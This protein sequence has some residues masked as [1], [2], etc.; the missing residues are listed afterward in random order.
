MSYY[1]LC[2]EQSGPAGQ[3]SAQVSLLQLDPRRQGLELLWVIFGQR[4]YAG[5]AAPQKADDVARGGVAYA[6]AVP[7]ELCRISLPQRA[8]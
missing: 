3:R 1:Q 4:L 6:I 8:G 7:S 5:T 2:W